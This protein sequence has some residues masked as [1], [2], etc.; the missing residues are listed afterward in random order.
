ME[1]DDR[2]QHPRIDTRL[3]VILYQGEQ[4]LA[5]RA[6]NVSLGGLGVTLEQQ[7]QAGEPV[8]LSFYLVKDGEVEETA[9]RLSIEG[10]VAWAT[11]LKQGKFDVGVAFGD[12]AEEARNRLETFLQR[13][14]AE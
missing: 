14:V 9:Q 2:R 4:I 7:V 11:P 8:T 10:K 6:N 1:N 13:L 3:S 12:V 5:A